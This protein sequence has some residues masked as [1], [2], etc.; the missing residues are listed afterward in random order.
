MSPSLVNHDNSTPP[1]NTLLVWVRPRKFVPYWRGCYAAKRPLVPGIC[2]VLLVVELEL[3]L[4]SDLM[5]K[6]LGQQNSH[7]L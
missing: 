4:I 3:Y 5:D 2:S 6:N 7:Q 1:A